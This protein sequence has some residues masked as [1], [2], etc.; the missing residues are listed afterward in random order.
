MP[1][2]RNSQVA[3][4]N[5]QIRAEDF[6]T[7]KSS[8]TLKSYSQ[9][10]NGDVSTAEYDLYFPATNPVYID[11]IGPLPDPV[12]GNLSY[13]IDE[14]LNTSNKQFIYN[15]V[16]KKYEWADAG[17]AKLFIQ[18][19]TVTEH[20]DEHGTALTVAREVPLEPGDPNYV[21]PSTFTLGINDPGFTQKYK[22]EYE[23]TDSL[24]NMRSFQASKADD[25]RPQLSASSGLFFDW[26]STPTRTEVTNGDG[27]YFTNDDKAQMDK[28]ILRTNQEREGIELEL[29]TMKNVVT[30]TSDSIASIVSSA[31]EGEA[32][33]Q[34][35][36]VT[37][38][39]NAAHNLET[40]SWI[41]ATG[42][43]NG[44]FEITADETDDTKFTFSPTP[45]ADT[46]DVSALAIESFSTTG[47]VITTADHGLLQDQYVKITLTN[48]DATNLKLS[49]PVTLLPVGY[50][51]VYKVTPAT[52]DGT[53]DWPKTFTITFPTAPVTTADPTEGTVKKFIDGPTKEVSK[54]ELDPSLALLKHYNV[55]LTSTSV[56]AERNKLVSSVFK[57]DTSKMTR[58]DSTMLPYESKWTFGKTTKLDAWNAVPT[59][60]VDD[61][62]GNM[63]EETNLQKADR[64]GA[65]P[66]DDAN[67]E[68][69]EGF[70]CIDNAEK[71]LKTDMEVIEFGPR[72]PG[73][74]HRLFVGPDSS[75]EPRL[76]IQKYKEDEWVGADVV[77]DQYGQNTAAVGFQ[78]DFVADQDAPDNA[79][80]GNI[81][82][83]LTELTGTL[84][85]VH[86]ALDDAPRTN[87]AAHKVNVS[88]LSFAS[89][90]NIT[91]S[92][93]TDSSAT[94]TIQFD[95]TL[96]S[97]AHP[98]GDGVAE[99]D[100]ITVN[101]TAMPKLN[102]VYQVPAGFTLTGDV[103]SFTITYE[104]GIAPVTA[105]A[106]NETTKVKLIKK[107]IQ[108]PPGYA[109]VH[110]IICYASG[111]ADD[112][113]KRVSELATATID[114][115]ADEGAAGVVTESGSTP[116]AQTNTS[117]VAP[118]SYAP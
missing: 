110:K 4:K 20:M 12:T 113:H 112:G 3:A 73:G 43:I 2:T 57:D 47:T 108:L 18:G 8:V 98:L 81:E 114:T 66:T 24:Y 67:D 9:A 111:P 116:L 109:G 115:S 33:D 100:F 52:D 89:A 83:T 17:D 41:R 23:F 91:I 26:T 32:A 101:S 96:D 30:I 35:S 37:V 118:P 86:V 36:I 80:T 103:F 38:T 79:Y 53:A 61:G 82:V 97:L 93:A 74:R 46:L 85:H 87:T 13:A 28:V 50:A 27:T 7:S 15:A 19:Q 76:Y 29:D 54:V 34:H 40:G 63:I 88:P 92:D 90:S 31:A 49:D 45:F 56:G 71:K 62:S 5:F 6:V 105:V 22:V 68:V 44:V 42:N 95:G 106:S 10:D 39:L 104:D 58:L 117:S 59:I 99:G 65:M 72:I 107:T 102:G 55:D 75:G 48:F 51:G 69:N 78:V 70:F 16:S 25:A 84:D 1:T 21:D 64:I 60:L 11:G 14:N 77:V 94:A